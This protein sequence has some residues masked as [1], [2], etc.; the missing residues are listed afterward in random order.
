MHIKIT[1]T[2]ADNTV[3]RY[4]NIMELDETTM[5]PAYRVKACLGRLDYVQRHADTLIRGLQNVKDHEKRRTKISVARLR[6]RTRK[7]RTKRAE[8]AGNRFSAR[9]RR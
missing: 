4:V 9:K 1:T 8:P 7:R 6:R 3:Y 5:P 2:R